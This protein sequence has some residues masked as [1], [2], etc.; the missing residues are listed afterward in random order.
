MY[1]RALHIQIGMLQHLRDFDLT[2]PLVKEKIRE[3]YPSGP[4]LDE[5]VISPEQ[6]A[7]SD[8]LETA[9]EE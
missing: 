2:H 6:M 9:A 4:P 1:D 7:K 8:L 3:R 5:T